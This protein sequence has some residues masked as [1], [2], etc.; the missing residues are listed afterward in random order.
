MWHFWSA[1]EAPLKPKSGSVR[2]QKCLRC[3]VTRPKTRSKTSIFNQKQHK[4]LIIN[5]LTQNSLKSRIFAF[6][7]ARESLIENTSIFQQIFVNI[8][9]RQETEDWS[10]DDTD[11]KKIDRLT[12]CFIHKREK[13]FCIISLD[14]FKNA[15][16][17]CLENLEIKQFICLKN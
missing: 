2:V 5:T 13:A 6:L 9:L 10:S 3:N 4:H 7:I 8:F 15:R 11:I 12:T 17:I 14:F 16:I 1:T